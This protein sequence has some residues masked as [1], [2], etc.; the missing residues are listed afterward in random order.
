MS[1]LVDYA[2]NE[3]R[4][5]GLLDKDSSYG[6][7]LGKAVLALVKTFAKQGHSGMNAEVVTH[8]FGIVARYKPLSPL[9]GDADEWNEVSQGLFQNRRCSSVFKENGQAYDMDGEVFKESSGATYPRS[10][11]RVPVTFPYLPHTVV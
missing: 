9:T 1:K 7:R 4:R 8:L 11:S 2:E 3:L 6:E 5:A 10:G